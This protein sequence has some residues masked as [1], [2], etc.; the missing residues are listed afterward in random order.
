MKV[1]ELKVM[2]F[3]GLSLSGI[4]AISQPILTLPIG[5]SEG[6]QRGSFSAD[7]KYILTASDDNTAKLWE[8]ASGK[9]IRTLN[10]HT[11]PITTS[12]FSKDGKMIVTTSQDGFVKGWETSS[13]A[14]L[15]SINIGSYVNG[16]TLSRDGEVM[17]VFSHHVSAKVFEVRSGKLIHT[18]IGHTK[19]I[20][21]ASFNHAGN[22]LVTA[23]NDKVAIVWD[24]RSGAALHKLIG[25][26]DFVNDA[27]F[28]SKGDI[29][30]TGS[31]DKSA[32]IW[33][34]TSAKM[35]ATLTG[36]TEGII[37]T[38]FNEAGD[39]VVTTSRDNSAK[40]WNLNGSVLHSLEGHLQ[41]VLG[42]S[43]SASGK[44]LLT[45]S[46][47]G[48]AKIWHT[49][50]GK[51]LRTTNAHGDG[52]TSAA[53]SNDA[54]V[55]LTTSLDKSAK[56][57]DTNNG[58]L[59]KLLVGRAQ[60]IEAIQVSATGKYVSVSAS[61]R[62]S[63]WEAASGNVVHT[64]SSIG[65]WRIGSNEQFIMQNSLTA[66]WHASSN[67]PPVF[68][69]ML[70]SVRLRDI[71]SGI[72]LADRSNELASV[73]M[74]GTMLASLSQSNLLTLASTGTGSPLFEVRLDAKP[75]SFEISSGNK[76]VCVAFENKVD[77]LD[78][79]NKGKLLHSLSHSSLGGAKLSND[80]RFIL[81]NGNGKIQIWELNTGRLVSTIKPPRY[82]TETTFS[83]NGEFVVSHVGIFGGS[84]TP[85]TIWRT[86]TGELVKTLAGTEGQTA[87]SF[88]E[89]SKLLFGNHQNRINVWDIVGGAM[90]FTNTNPTHN[91]LGTSVTPDTKHIFAYDPESVYILDVSTGKRV[92]YPSLSRISPGPPTFSP[93]LTIDGR[94]VITNDNRT[95]IKLFD[96]KTELESL[97]WIV[98]DS[99]DWVVTH[100]SGL[101]D[102]S[103]NAMNQL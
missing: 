27:M 94:F 71:K 36:H 18:L 85:I 83:P 12:I 19:S 86:K 11:K 72:I 38:S 67:A 97:S 54:S 10:G 37:T 4:T 43:F 55:Y 75:N 2:I 28:N 70:G 9:L 33:D 35:L 65:N 45:F 76:Y 1:A 8:A 57:W 17:V 95:R 5:H 60:R 68:R 98:L 62:Q 22:L 40:L 88:S 100:P 32:K 80:S 103:P 14:L 77:V 53:F 39:V 41:D 21:N 99:S 34:A 29:I 42:A 15:Y 69:S 81:T 59:S 20:N 89:D 63:I 56:V 64:S 66:R 47:D 7:D 44:Y 23:S 58:G 16:A 82:S 61:D 31:D 92:Q 49:T 96:I 91:Y 87:L 52:V 74:D 50:T 78:A 46:D 3:L 25:H 48:T 93:E 6:I 73:S 84:I 51:L 90:V 26:S 30:V 101:F 79:G 13:G 102:A 24:T